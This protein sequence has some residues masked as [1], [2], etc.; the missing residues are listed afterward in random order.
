[1]SDLAQESAAVHVNHSH[2]LKIQESSQPKLK[3]KYTEQAFGT[4]GRQ[5]SQTSHLPRGFS[6]HLHQKGG[7]GETHPITTFN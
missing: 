4:S 6:N 2:I 1:M 7:W 3:D 5:F